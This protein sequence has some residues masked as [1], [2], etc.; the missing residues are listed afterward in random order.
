M[1]S[2]AV[3]LA[4]KHQSIV[5]AGVAA[6]LH[7]STWQNKVSAE[8]EKR[9]RRWWNPLRTQVLPRPLTPN[10][11]IWSL[12]NSQ[13]RRRLSDDKKQ[14][15]LL[16]KIR[17]E[18]AKASATPEELKTKQQLMALLQQQWLDTVYGQG[19]S[20]M[21]RRDFVEQYGCT[22]YNEEILEE[23]LTLAKEH[24]GIL[25]MG[26]GN[27][28]WARALSDRYEQ[29]PE[30]KPG[31]HIVLAYDDGSQLPLDPSIYH[32]KTKPAHDYFYPHV[33][34][35]L[36]NNTSIEHTVQQWSCRGR[37]LL[38]VYPPPG[39]MAVRTVRAYSAVPQGKHTLVYVGEGRGG[40][41]A[42]ED[43]FRLLEESGWIVTKV[44]P[45]KSFGTKGYEKMYILQ[46][47]LSLD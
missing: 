47:Q 21:D 28:Q 17:S 3:L 12:T 5:V 43:F 27:G 32:A 4:T 2:Q 31:F 8:E 10:D 14:H 36:S 29:D 34:P 33:Q 20:L 25:E 18:A 15:D 1:N 26:A 13:K 44:L 46:K 45:V 37:A 41:N 38:L 39:D 16:V 7:L 22:G 9:Q 24:G 11:A 30:R 40:A 42:D 19:V 23:L 6:V 35:L